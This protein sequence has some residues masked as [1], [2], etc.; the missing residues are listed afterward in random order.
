MHIGIFTD[1]YMP[2]ING[3]VTSI[4]I[5]EEELRKLGHRVTVVTVKVP[6]LE[7]ESENILRIPSVPFSRWSEFRLGIPIYNETYRKI[8]KLG[9]DVIHTQTEFTV[10]I[11]GKH[12]AAVMD[13]PLVHTYHTMY[14]DYTH[15][16]FDH[17]YGKKL[18]RR[19]ITTTS[20]L[21]VRKYDRIIAPS[22]KTLEALRSYGVVADIRIV[23]TGI[24]IQKFKRSTDGLSQKVLRQRY[25][26]EA[27][28]YLMLSLGRVSK[29]KSVDVLIEQMPQIV[30]AIPR[31]K[32]LIVGDGPYRSDL[33]SLVKKLKLSE[34]VVFAGQV[35][36]GEVSSFYSAA[37]LFVNASKSETQGLTII[38]AMASDLPLVVYDDLNVEGIVIHGVTGRL[39]KDNDALAKQIV[40]AYRNSDATQRMTENA[41]EMVQ[42]LSKEKFALKVEEIYDDLIRTT[43]VSAI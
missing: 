14:E 32:L 27:D 16:V 5:L 39:F 43:V 35:P 28:D 26:I 38:E 34:H 4:Q 33:E 1:C 11:I 15:Y 18:L 10:G 8:R 3:V 9:L 23:P 41:I 12:M 24:D 20:K 29:E 37:D 22:A 17:K 21:Y 42:N 2:Q 30:E 7:E 31:A 13:I 36:F 6:G 19:L 40:L 25:G